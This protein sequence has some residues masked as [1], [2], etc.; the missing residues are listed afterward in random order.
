MVCFLLWI[1][2]IL[3]YIHVV[4]HNMNSFG[5]VCVWGEV[6][7]SFASLFICFLVNRV[8]QLF[9]YSRYISFIRC[10][11]YEYLFSICGLSFHSLNS[12][13]PFLSNVYFVIQYFGTHYMCSNCHVSYSWEVITCA[14]KQIKL[15]NIRFHHFQ[16]TIYNTLHVITY[17]N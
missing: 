8:G 9:I 10:I 11:I 14:K 5:C 3:R 2:I 6:F 17:L 4:A 12:F 7:K 13:I 16:L 15:T 1:V